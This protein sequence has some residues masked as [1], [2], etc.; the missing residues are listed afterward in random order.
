MSYILDALKRAEQQR[1]APARGAASL[2]RAIASDFEAR[3]RWP[4]VVGGLASLAV[5]AS[6]IAFWP[7]RETTV[8][9]PELPAATPASPVAAPLPPPASAVAGAPPPA[10]A[11][12]PIP[13]RVEPAP[14]RVVSAPPAQR[15]AAPPPGAVA[16]RAGPPA[17]AARSAGSRGAPA[18]TDDRGPAGRVA[19][20]PVP[21]PTARVEPRA[22]APTGDIARPAPPRASSPA[23]SPPAVAAPPAAPA[24]NLKALAATLSIQVLSWAPERKDRF[25]FL[26][27]RKYG[28]GQM[29]DDKILIEQI[30][31]DGVVLS[32]QGERLTLKGR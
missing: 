8:A 16:R 24:G 29:V 5:V 7:S 17:A 32:Y 28:E 21:R 27:G 18:A 6:A 23:P 20:S 22:P 26:A 19:P 14:L 1:G 12:P 31:E 30:T 25:V 4:W 15:A 2:P 10:E 3:A 9:L 11:V 13:P